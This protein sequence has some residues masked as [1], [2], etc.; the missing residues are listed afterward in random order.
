MLPVSK[1]IQPVFHLLNQVARSMGP[2]INRKTDENIREAGFKILRE[3][4][5]FASV[6]RLIEIEAVKK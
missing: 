4:K 6:F 1:I 5:L 3:E 2:E